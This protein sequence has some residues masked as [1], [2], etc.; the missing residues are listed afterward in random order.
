M[1]RYCEMLICGWDVPTKKC[2][3][4]EILWFIHVSIP[5][6]VFFKIIVQSVVLIYISSYERWLESYS[7]TK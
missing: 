3:H 2:I 7:S 4:H 6:D 1:K 5:F